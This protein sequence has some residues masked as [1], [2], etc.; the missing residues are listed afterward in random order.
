MI[1]VDTTVAR[2]VEGI[3]PVRVA[4][5]AAG[6]RPTRSRRLSPPRDVVTRDRDWRPL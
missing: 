5:V 1:I 2:R 3:D 4:G 6:D